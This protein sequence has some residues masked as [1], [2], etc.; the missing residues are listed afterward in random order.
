MFAHK[1][2]AC[3]FC[4]KTAAEVSKLVAG[5]S[6][7]ICDVCVAEAHRIMSDPSIGASPLQSQP[8]PNIWRR[9]RAWLVGRRSSRETVRASRHTGPSCAI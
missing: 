5:P 2:L 1:K 6:I 9:F 8:V 3:S 7:F 4:G